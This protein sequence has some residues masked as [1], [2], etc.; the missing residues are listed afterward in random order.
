MNTVYAFYF[1]DHLYEKW[2]LPWVI[3]GPFIAKTVTYTSPTWSRH[4]RKPQTTPSDWS[5]RPTGTPIKKVPSKFKQ[6]KNLPNYTTHSSSSNSKTIP[7]KIPLGYYPRRAVQTRRKRETTRQYLEETTRDSRR[8]WNWQSTV[9]SSGT[10][11]WV[12]EAT[13]N[14]I[15]FS[16]FAILNHKVND[17]WKWWLIDGN[18][19]GCKIHELDLST[20]VKYKN[21][22]APCIFYASIMCG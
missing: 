13:R 5:S 22:R 19:A 8:S 16:V 4:F 15:F 6:S 2:T 21:V 17:G 18:C 20:G 3:Q 11:K 1:W 10:A 14:R 7:T 9:A 12:T